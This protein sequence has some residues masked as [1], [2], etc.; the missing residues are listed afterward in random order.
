V[1][2][3]PIESYPTS[4]TLQCNSLEPIAP[5]GCDMLSFQMMIVVVLG[6]WV[7]LSFPFAIIVGRVIATGTGAHQSAVHPD[8]WAK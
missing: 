3:L 7:M 2:F 1:N 8:F 4:S 6:A 5:L